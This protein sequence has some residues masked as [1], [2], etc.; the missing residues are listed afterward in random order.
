M[1][2]ITAIRTAAISAVIRYCIKKNWTERHLRLGKYRWEKK[3]WI[4]ILVETTVW[5][6]NPDK[7]PFTTVWFKIILN[8]K[9]NPDIAETRRYQAVSIAH[10]SRPTD[11]F[12]W[13][14][15]DEK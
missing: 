4:E 1:L 3:D 6:K 10:R 13:E 11:K 15:I 9:S 8:R 5:K 7:N 12:E 2:N 14:A